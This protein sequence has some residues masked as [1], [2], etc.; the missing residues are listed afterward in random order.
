MERQYL[1]ANELDEIAR[2][3]RRLEFWTLGDWFYSIGDD[4]SAGR[5]TGDV[6]SRYEAGTEGKGEVLICEWD[7]NCEHEWTAI[8]RELAR[9]GETL[10]ERCRVGGMTPDDALWALGKLIADKWPK[11]L[12][13]EW[14]DRVDWPTGERDDERAELDRV[15]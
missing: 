11:I 2:Q 8:F 7:P 9:D 12:D 5:D 6:A 1:D 4:D 15:D 10:L 13:Q 14:P 3:L